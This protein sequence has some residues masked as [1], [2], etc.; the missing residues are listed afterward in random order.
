MRCGFGFRL[1]AA[2]LGAL[3]AVQPGAAYAQ[4]PGTL[5]AAARDGDLTA[6]RGALAGGADLE[7]RD[8]KG[9]TPLMFASIRGYEQLAELLLDAGADVNARAHDGSTPLIAAAT[10]GELEIARALLKRGADP[11][12]EN[13]AGASAL[14][15]AKQYGHAELVRL[16]ET[17]GN[18]TAQPE[19]VP[20]PPDTALQPVV[21]PE[22]AAQ[23]PRP[24]PEPEI[25]PL[26]ADFVLRDGANIRARPEGSS[27]KVGALPAGSVVRVLGKVRGRNW[28]RVGSWES[29][30]Y[31]WGD[32]LT[33]LVETKEQAQAQAQ[34]QAE[35]D[36]DPEPETVE[37]PEPRPS[38]S[39]VRGAASETVPL[40]D[41][42]AIEPAVAPAALLAQLN[43]RWTSWRNPSSC[44]RDF[45]EIEAT[46]YSLN[47]R[48]HV[49]GEITP[50]ASQVPVQSIDPSQLVA[51]SSDLKWR[52]VV[53][54]NELR[55]A[56]GN[57]NEVL[58]FRCPTSASIN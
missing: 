27:E 6:A 41:P 49:G 13:S 2:L 58:Y 16:I 40:P 7:A 51:G 4:D 21:P 9:W 45:L 12:L 44:T 14:V 55:Y 28:Y 1:F 24:K 39:E 29:S 50:L 26:D 19:D 38:I 53:E 8:P 35:P 46:A 20:E 30:H 5:L 31:I 48:V 43:G 15:K 32:L 25:E 18:K 17:A 23:T 11:L 56:F 22:Q 36:P 3:L 54:G 10:M 52:L 33:P 37:E 34:A 47:L 57:G 42:S